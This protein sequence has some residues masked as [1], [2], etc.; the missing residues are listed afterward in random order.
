MADTANSRQ[1]GGGHYKMPGHEEHWDRAWRLNWDPFQYQIT[2]YVERW[3]DKNGV[4]DLEK[5]RH[6]LDKYIELMKTSP[7]PAPQPWFNPEP[8]TIPAFMPAPVKQTGYTNFTF[9]GGSAEWD[10]YTCRICR[11]EVKVPPNTSPVEFHNHD[12]TG[13]QAG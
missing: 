1:V 3:K 10:L 6:F 8:E 13:G 7:I 12:I 4:Q 5:A 9:E 2:K 11:V